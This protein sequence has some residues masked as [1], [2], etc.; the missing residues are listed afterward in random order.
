VLRSDGQR[1]ADGAGRSQLLDDRRGG[2][3]SRA[4]L[5]AGRPSAH[6]NGAGSF[7]PASRTAGFRSGSAVGL[8]SAPGTVTGWTATGRR[9]G[10]SSVAWDVPA[11]VMTSTAFGTA[12]GSGWDRQCQRSALRRARGSSQ[13]PSAR[14]T[15][16]GRTP[17]PTTAGSSSHRAGLPTQRSAR[18]AVVTGQNAFT[19]STPTAAG[20]RASDRSSVCSSVSALRSGW[21]RRA[22]SCAQAAI[23]E[24][25]S[26]SGSPPRSKPT[27]A[28]TTPAS[29]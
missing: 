19:Y 22:T 25:G 1:A 13:R 11:D 27:A 28:R 3:A 6:S 23:S 10:S 26:Y 12:A 5:D 17:P 29:R 15:G 14:V 2:W 4:A 7:P 20:H 16:T 9:V 24:P 21:A 18:S 8:V